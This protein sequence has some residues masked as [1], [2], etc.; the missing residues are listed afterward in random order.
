MIDRNSEW[1]IQNNS[2][3]YS[4]YR[5]IFGGYSSSY[6]DMSYISLINLCNA[7][8]FG[9][10]IESVTSP[11]SCAS[12]TR[13]IFGGGFS[14]SVSSALIEYITISSNSNAYS[15]GNLT[16]G[17]AGIAACS[18]TTRGCFAGG[19][20][21]DGPALNTIDYITIA[22]TGN[23]T[24]FG[25]MSIKREGLSACGSTVYGIYGGGAY[26]SG[27]WYD[28]DLIERITYSTTG[29]ITT[30]GNLSIKRY[31]LSACSSSSRG[32]FNG[33]RNLELSTD[34]S[35]IDYITI[36][37]TGNASNFGNLTGARDYTAACS[38]WVLG[39]I[40]GGWEEIEGVTNAIDYVTI[41]TTGD[42]SD[43]GDLTHKQGQFSGLS[44]CHGGI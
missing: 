14:G 28:T 12:D 11:G 3:L 22:T 30:F 8:E 36:T 13:G 20:E 32:L 25:D 4:P 19:H 23:A 26:V 44:N 29:I 27:V 35:S 43:F 38:S 39:V 17:R 9:E 42:A 34:L 1:S 41:A 33:G 40:A 10:L 7:A 6:I 24:D 37:T 21:Q 2:F 18:N 15:F 16:V 5:G 31:F